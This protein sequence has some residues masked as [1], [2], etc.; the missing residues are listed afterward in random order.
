MANYVKNKDL[1]NEI[2]KSLEQDELTEEA[3]NM[4]ILIAN[5]SINKLSFDDEADKKDCI[6]SGIIDMMKYW[7]SF[8]PKYTNAF[9][10]FTQ[11]CKN[12]FAKGWNEI[13]PK[14]AKNNIRINN[15]NDNEIYSI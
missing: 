2:C 3:M 6:S 8:N 15:N 9:A 12:G 7:K 11:I 1:Y 10:Y 13:H 4:F 14:K 5:N